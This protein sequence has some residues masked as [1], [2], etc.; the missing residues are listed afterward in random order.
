MSN[1]GQDSA[2]QRDSVSGA[3]DARNKTPVSTVPD[4]GLILA[5]LLESVVQPS[6]GHDLSTMGLLFNKSRRAVEP[7]ASVLTAEGVHN[8]Q[9]QQPQS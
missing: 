5:R 9:K 1:L 4:L 6:A 2:Q 7:G 8:L 3:A